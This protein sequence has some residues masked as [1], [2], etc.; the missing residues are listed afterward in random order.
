M[1]EAVFLVKDRV[2]DFA[3]FESSDHIK[4]VRNFAFR[5]YLEPEIFLVIETLLYM[6][7]GNIGTQLIFTFDFSENCI[8]FFVTYIIPRVNQFFTIHDLQRLALVG[9][10]PA[11]EFRIVKLNR[12]LGG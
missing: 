7:V 6:D 10:F 4:L 12:F 2:K 9:K 1:L 3:D 8:L 11:P 5:V